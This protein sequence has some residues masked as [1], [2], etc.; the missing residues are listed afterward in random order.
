MRSYSDLIEFCKK[1]KCDLV[2]NQEE[3]D[4]FKDSKYKFKFIA[5]MQCG[6]EKKTSIRR[7]KEHQLCIKCAKK[8]KKSN[9]NSKSSY[10]DLN[11]SEFDFIYNILNL[12]FDVKQINEKRRIFI[13][14]KPHNINTN[15]W[16]YIDVHTYTSI[17]KNEMSYN[18][19][20]NPSENY[21]H[22][23]ICKQKNLIWIIY[24]KFDKL[25]KTTFSINP[26]TKYSKY[27][28]E[29]NEI[30]NKLTQYYVIASKIKYVESSQ[31]TSQS[32]TI[33]D[34]YLT[35]LKNYK[36]NQFIDLP[37]FDKVYRI[38]AQNYGEIYRIVFPSGK[39]YIGQVLLLYGKNKKIYG[40][41]ARFREHVHDSKKENGGN[42]RLLNYALRKYG[43]EN[44][45]LE[46]LTTVKIE[47]MTRYE[48]Y[49]MNQYNSMAPNGYNLKSGGRC[50]H[51]S[52][53]MIANRK[54]I[55]GESHHNY[56][57]KLSKEHRE[58]ISKKLIDN[59][60][61]YGHDG[62]KLPKYIKYVVKID[63][64]GY[65]IYSHP[66]CKERTFSSKSLSLEEKKKLALNYLSD[67]DR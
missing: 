28:C 25:I 67:L 50:G 42:C 32:N 36:I 27:L 46:V 18:F 47:E 29:I 57:K 53:E 5:I 39:S 11:Q 8:H 56:G 23:M 31:N 20:I 59:V 2:S 12:K 51:Y 40:S 30:N 54:Y 33:S 58:K 17:G 19:T 21:I 49:F 48:D 64:E 26:G 61:R 4:N 45:V 9:S 55:K 16:V 1:Y 62:L 65:G 60:I 6:H 41:K 24:K 43:K 7:L 3:Y 37:V 38:K 44:T 52:P 35:A 63:R 22:M 14:I 13:L 66:L 10:L 15:E 34:I